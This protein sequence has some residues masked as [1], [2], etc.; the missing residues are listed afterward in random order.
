MREGDKFLSVCPHCG[1]QILSPPLPLNW[2]EYTP[3]LVSFLCPMCLEYVYVQITINP[4]LT[5]EIAVEN[6]ESIEEDGDLLQSPFR[7]N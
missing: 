7:C 4:D 3:L 5:M 1:M 2:R 6:V